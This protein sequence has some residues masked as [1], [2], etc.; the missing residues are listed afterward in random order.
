VSALR[1]KSAL[2]LLESREK[3]IKISKRFCIV[4]VAGNL[5]V[6]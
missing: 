5:A 2:E 6:D 1:G 4:E 3:K